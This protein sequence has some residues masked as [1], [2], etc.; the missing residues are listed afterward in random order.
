[1]VWVGFKKFATKPDDTAPVQNGIRAVGY[2]GV[3]TLLWVWP[4]HFAGFEK[5]EMP[6]LPTFTDLLFNAFLDLI[7]NM[8]LFVCITLSSP[9]VAT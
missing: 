9:L 2:I 6:D 7:F 5:F 4:L 8:S 3:H 1:M